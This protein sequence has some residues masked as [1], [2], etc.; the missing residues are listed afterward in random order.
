MATAKHTVQ[1]WLQCPVENDPLL[2]CVILPNEIIGDTVRVVFA[3]CS[4]ATSG[5][6]VYAET[7]LC[8][9]MSMDVVVREAFCVY[10][11]GAG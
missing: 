6:R 4:M 9:G 7:A 8:T 5:A 3:N 11:G 1:E 2:F 10:A